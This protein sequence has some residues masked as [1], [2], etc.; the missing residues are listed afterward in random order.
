MDLCKTKRMKHYTLYEALFPLNHYIKEENEK[1]MWKR[2]ESKQIRLY[3]D[4]LKRHGW[5]K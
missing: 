4:R 3:N 2:G 1:T 5:G